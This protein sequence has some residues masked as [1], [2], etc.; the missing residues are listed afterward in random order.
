MSWKD[1][2]SPRQKMLL[3]QLESVL[4]VAQ[5]TTLP[6]QVLEIQGYG[7]FFRG[8]PDARDVDVSVKFGEEHRLFKLYRE[9]VTEM[10]NDFNEIDSEKREKYPTPKD[11]FDATYGKAVAL[12]KYGE[13]TKNMIALFSQWLDGITWSMLSMDERSGVL[14]SEVLSNKIL[15][16]KAH[17][18]NVSIKSDGLGLVTST[19]FTLWSPE[20]PDYKENIRQ[21]FERVRESRLS[22]LKEFLL[23]IVG[24]K[25]QE[26]VISKIIALTIERDYSK[27]EMQELPELFP[28]L[29][30]TRLEDLYDTWNN[31]DE[32]EITLA[33]LDHDRELDTGKYQMLPDDELGKLVE[34]KRKELKDR[35]RSVSVMQHALS[36]L[37]YT[38][39]ASKVEGR[40]PHHKIAGCAALFTLKEINK[41]KADEKKIREVLRQ[42]GLPEDRVKTTVRK[43][44]RTRYRLMREH[45]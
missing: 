5:R 27:I 18:R 30:R 12:E 16:R 41:K 34:Q 9:T 8:K 40:I 32:K 20:E 38:I 36:Q 22:S 14:Y 39:Y 26:E 25:K 24:V 35:T 19:V 44:E 17:A 23:Q 21:V 1:N 6:R 7:S 15:K 37:N 4:E 29:S 11:F 33:G 13:E 2:L 28:Q 10:Y 43:G 31:M 45:F 42:I 3:K